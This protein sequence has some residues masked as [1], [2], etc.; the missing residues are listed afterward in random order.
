ML[1]T[2]VLESSK[3]KNRESELEKKKER[4]IVLERSWGLNEGEKEKEGGGDRDGTMCVEE[5]GDSVEKKKKNI[6]GK[7]KN[8]QTDTRM[9]E[10]KREK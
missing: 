5:E 2:T 4:M 8:T 6:Y 7:K 3:K 1:G 9:D 10:M